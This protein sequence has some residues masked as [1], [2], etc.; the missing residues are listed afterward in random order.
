MDQLSLSDTSTE[1]IRTDDDFKENVGMAALSHSSSLF[2]TLRIEETTPNS[3]FSII[4][5][6][7][8]TTSS[9][10]TA[11]SSPYSTSP[12]IL[13]STRHPDA[14]RLLSETVGQASSTGRC[15]ITE[16][17]DEP[18]VSSSALLDACLKTS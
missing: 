1:L 14:A 17:T 15:V 7:T 4:S 16:P 9:S 11:I 13:D 6:S 3:S 18:C 2:S 8:N 10:T 12:G 5:G